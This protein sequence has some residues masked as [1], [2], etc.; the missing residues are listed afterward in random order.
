V[1]FL[2][3][4]V[5][6]VLWAACGAGIALALALG[7]AFATGDRPFTVMSGSMHPEIEVGD[8]VVSRPISPMQARVGDVITFRD[9]MDKRR[10]I[11]HRLRSIE[12]RAG[13]VHAVTKGD[14][15]N[16]VERW[17]VPV[18]ATIGRVVVRVPRIGYVLVLA[19]SRDGRLLLIVV[20]VVLLGLLELVRI[21]RPRRPAP[22]YGAAVVR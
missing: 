18:G 22:A 20:P 12:V 15:N 13:V 4:P 6:F 11:T 8:V 10:M 1:S 7:V 2:M 16:T 21:W 14:A 9:P 17:T 5:R 3:Q 19:R